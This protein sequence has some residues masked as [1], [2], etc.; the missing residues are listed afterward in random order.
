MDKECNFYRLWL[1]IIELSHHV[2]QVVLLFLRHWF[3]VIVV[4]LP[5]S[6]EEVLHGL[7]LGISR[8]VDGCVGTF[9]KQLIL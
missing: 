2:L 5:E 4:I 1:L 6:R 3:V 8:G 9:G 7:T